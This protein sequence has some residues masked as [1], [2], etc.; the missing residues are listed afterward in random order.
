MLSKLAPFQEMMLTL[1]RLR[2]SSSIQDLAYRFGVHYSTISHIFFK[3]LT[4]FDAKLK[5]LLL[6]PGRE[7][8]RRIMP[9]CF[10]ASFKDKVADCF[11]VFIERPS[12]LMARAA[13]WSTYK[14]HNT[15]KF[16]ID[17]AP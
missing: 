12:N 3:W 10:C 11:E 8:L 14:L 7:D 4:M 13:T 6:W 9:E 16:L 2:L 15:A 17:I 5:P 1:V